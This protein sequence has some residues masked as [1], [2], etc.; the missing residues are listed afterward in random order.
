MFFNNWFYL[1]GIKFI[2]GKKVFL[3]NISR[4]IVVFVIRYF[5]YSLGFIII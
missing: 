1:F 3:I 2:D 4:L 5:F